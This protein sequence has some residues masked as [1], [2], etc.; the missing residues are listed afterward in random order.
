MAHNALSRGNSGDGVSSSQ[1]V[2]SFE[3]AAGEQVS[4]IG[5][6]CAGLAA[7]TNANAPVSPG[8]AV[9]TDAYTA[10]IYFNR[11]ELRDIL[12]DYSI[13]WATGVDPMAPKL[14]GEKIA[15]RRKIMEAL[16]S[17]QGVPALNEPPETITEPFTIMLWGITSDAVKS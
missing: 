15:A 17:E 2:I 4:R 12:F 8:F 6:K 9:T 16:A 1:Y 3:A 11:N 10:M 7:L 13:A 14:F 5:G